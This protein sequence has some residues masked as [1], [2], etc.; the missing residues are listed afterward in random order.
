MA[1]NK[2][3]I[4]LTLGIL[5]ALLHAVWALLVGLGYA[6]PFLDWIMKLHFMGMPLLIGGFSL[7]RAIT[8]IVVTFIA[9]FI[10]GWLFGAIWNWLGN[11]VK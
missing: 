10:F 11:K 9:G 5:F 8:L 2:N 7:G 4:G 1:I 6:Q 3:K